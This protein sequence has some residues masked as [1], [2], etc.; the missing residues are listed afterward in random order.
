MTTRKIVKLVPRKLI[1]NYLIEVILGG[2]LSAAIYTLIS[3]KLGSTL[4]FMFSLVVLM[5]II[6]PFLIYRLYKYVKVEKIR[7]INPYIVGPP[8]RNPNDFFG[9]RNEVH[10]FYDRL[11]GS[12]LQ[13]SMILA[14]NRAGKTS[15]LNY[16]SNKETLDRYMGDY[17]V[18]IIYVDLNSGINN[19]QDFYSHVYNK[20]R[21]KRKISYSIPS[22]ME[23][24]KQ[25]L[26]RLGE[27]NRK[28]VILLDEFETLASSDVFDSNFFIGLR[29]LV[30]Y[31]DIALC[32]ASFRNPHQNQSDKIKEFLDIFNPDPIYLG[33]LD[34]EEADDLLK[35]PA[36]KVS[37]SLSTEDILAIKTMAGGLPS[38][39]QHVA[40]LWYEYKERYSKALPQVQKLV[41]AEFTQ[42]Q[43]SYFSRYI[44]QLNPDETFILTLLAG[45]YPK[46]NTLDQHESKQRITT[47]K[48]LLNYGI[49]AEKN[50]GYYISSSVFANWLKQAI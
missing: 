33:S 6:T 18:L 15:F 3:E 25:I 34:L 30:S 40:H 7:H 44:G 17:D 5:I 41:E 43:D 47:V 22:D 46:P 28:V 37:F 38:C 20:I 36:E 35:R 45:E 42:Q 48:D 29:S 27:K 4:T 50:E 12:Q 23:G 13:S 10:T 19:P 16:V 11:E 39:L 1:T 21:E 14:V 9:R 24:F 49:I 2:I 8:I 31:S 26:T 32:T